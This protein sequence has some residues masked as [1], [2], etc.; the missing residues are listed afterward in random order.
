MSLQTQPIPETAQEA[1]NAL[2]RGDKTQAR[3]LLEQ[4]LA[5]HPHDK[6]LWMW[7]AWAAET[8]AGR[9]QCLQRLLELDPENHVARQW[10]AGQRDASQQMVGS[11]ALEKLLAQTVTSQ[12][13]TRPGWRLTRRQLIRFLIACLAVFMLLGVWWFWQ[14]S[15]LDEEEVR[16]GYLPLLSLRA[17]VLTI[18]ETAQ[19]VQSAESDD[20]TPYLSGL[21]ETKAIILKVQDDLDQTTPP[22]PP[23]LFAPAWQEA[24]RAVPTLDD[25][26]DRWLNNEITAANIPVELAPVRAQIDHAL[27]IAEDA[28]S[29]RYGADRETLREIRE[30]LLADIRAD[31]QR[32]PTPTPYPTP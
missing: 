15:Y 24:E 1:I 22:Y 17:A 11:S 7:L 16:A 32:T 26:V 10:L 14:R 4:A 18:E 19:Q 5:D 3:E 2:Q 29:R 21:I 25:V 12:Q 8:E 30:E 20:L 31:L 28:L 13:Q 27:T 23:T 6:R 9:E